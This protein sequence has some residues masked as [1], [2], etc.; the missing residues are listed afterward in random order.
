MSSLFVALYSGID[1]RNYGEDDDLANPDSGENMATSKARW[2]M[3]HIFVTKA[4]WIEKK[5]ERISRKA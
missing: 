3:M 2:V 5:L 1:Y 4:A